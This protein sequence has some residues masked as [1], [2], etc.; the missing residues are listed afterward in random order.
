MPFELHR[1][2][3][4]RKDAEK[5]VTIRLCKTSSEIFFPKAGL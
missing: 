2:V 4:Q 1:L 5:P 3:F